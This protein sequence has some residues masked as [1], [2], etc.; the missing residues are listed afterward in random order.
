MSEQEYR[1]VP[2]AY[3]LV[4]YL[5]LNEQECYVS[6]VMSLKPSQGHVRRLLERL[7]EMFP[8]VKIPNPIHP[9]MVHLAESLGFTRTREYWELAN[10]WIDVWVWEARE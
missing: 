8:S 9:A 2:L 7:Q 6:A 10:E 1:M 4:G 3:P 5:S